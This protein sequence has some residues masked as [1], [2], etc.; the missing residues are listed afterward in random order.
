MLRLPVVDRRVDGADPQREA[1]RDGVEAAVAEG[2]A[3]QQAPGAQD[4]APGRPE[5]VDRLRRVGRAGRLIAA[6]A[7]ET[8]EI[9][10]L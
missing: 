5:A 8:G 10:R 6:A 1:R 7:R 9:Q 4:R 3:A 2:V